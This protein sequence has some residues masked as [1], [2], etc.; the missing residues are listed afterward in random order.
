MT[1]C[2]SLDV[3][4]MTIPRSVKTGRTQGAMRREQICDWAQL[5]TP[6]R[7]Q[8]VAVRL[9]LIFYMLCFMFLLLI[10]RSTVV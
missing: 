8:T 1:I 2:W 3:T 4:E 10:C 5:K 9:L 6:Y 7:R